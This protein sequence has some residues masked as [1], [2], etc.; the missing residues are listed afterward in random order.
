[1]DQARVQQRCRA[2]R[3]P[4]ARR[5]WIATGTSISSA[6][7]RTRTTCSGTRTTD[8][9]P[10]QLDALDRRRIVR[11]RSIRDHRRRGRGPGYLDVLAAAVNADDVVWYENDGTPA[12]NGWTKRTIDPLSTAHPRPCRRTSMAT[13][14]V[15]VLAAGQIAND[16]TVVRE[17][18][19]RS[20]RLDPPHDRRYGERRPSGCRR[21]SRSRWG[22]GP[23]GGVCGRRHDRLVS[24]RHD[25]SQRNVFARARRRP[26]AERGPGLCDRRHGR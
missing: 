16:V 1:M 2:E 8:A 19:S 24:Q 23:H 21:G 20:A 13:G 6:R 26:V 14:I 10:G 22:H 17:R 3:S 5:T 7:L 11:R 4:S 15:D 25:P 12:G 18:W 9:Q